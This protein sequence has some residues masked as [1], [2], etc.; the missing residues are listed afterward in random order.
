[1]PAWPIRLRILKA[2]LYFVE[3]RFAK[4]KQK[5]KARWLDGF[6]SSME[7][8]PLLNRA[9][10]REQIHFLGLTEHRNGGSAVKSSFF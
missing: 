7:T 2:N 6:A 8:N 1:M 3:N 5:K 9:G 10:Q 4:S